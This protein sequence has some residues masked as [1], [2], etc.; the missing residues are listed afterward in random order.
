[1]P[2]AVMYRL[3]SAA[4][5]RLVTGVVLLGATAL[6]AAVDPHDAGRY[7]PCPWH[8]MTGT[9]CPGCGGLRAVHDLAHGQLASALGE[10][11]LVVACVPVV[12]VW[13]LI[14]RMGGRSVRGARAAGGVGVPQRGLALG[15]RLTSAVTVL[16]LLFALLRNLPIG[17]GLAP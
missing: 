6:V 16:A 7:P 9:W 11:V 14:T 2:V 5:S 17:A 8:A 1:M 10:N 13:W 12:G 4:V 3:H 15:P